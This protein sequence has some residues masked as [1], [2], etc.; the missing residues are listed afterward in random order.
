MSFNRKMGE[1]ETVFNE[2]IT[3][4]AMMYVRYDFKRPNGDEIFHTRSKDHR[5]KYNYYLAEQ[6]ERNQVKHKN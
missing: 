6:A 2:L 3:Y 4:H 5:Q 1:W